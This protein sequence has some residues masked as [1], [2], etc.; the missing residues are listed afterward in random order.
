MN[1]VDTVALALAMMFQDI[2]IQKSE[3][4]LKRAWKAVK[5]EADSLHRLSKFVPR[6][7]GI[8]RIGMKQRQPSLSF[9]PANDSAISDAYASPVE[10]IEGSG[11]I[12]TMSQIGEGPSDGKR[13]DKATLLSD[14]SVGDC[15]VAPSLQWTSSFGLTD[16]SYLLLQSLTRTYAR[17]C[18][19]DLKMGTETFEP[20]CSDEKRR[21][22]SSKYAMQGVFGFRI[23]GMRIYDPD[24]QE[25]D[26]K[27]F[28]L[29]P[30]HYG[31]SLLEREQVVEA[32]RLF[33]GSG[34]K[35]K[36]AAAEGAQSQSLNG[37]ANATSASSV[38][39]RRML[40]DEDKCS[41]VRT[42]AVSSLLLQL[43]SLRRWFEE[44]N[45]A[46]QFR[47][48]SL[49]FIYEGDPTRGGNGDV[50]MLKMI[51]FGHVRR[52]PGGD[53]GYLNGI[54]NLTLILTEIL[55]YDE[56]ARPS[57]NRTLPAPQMEGLPAPQ[58][59]GR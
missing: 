13:G 14:P 35:R 39:H 32:F 27:G 25:S 7:R 37:S 4:E 55:T 2:V 17:P 33:F 46:L 22:E 15:H 11:S 6:C 9:T 45:T 21:R 18:V 52:A 1:V 49:L 3:E 12:A 38:H 16:D 53:T 47:A 42:K 29:F 30:K 54:K 57:T 41:S 56:V 23:I 50:T 5:R 48:S 59:E 43:R 28:R 51:D 10:C 34:V 19:M 20:D 58:M 26:D 36:S 44:H 40:D 31:R 24:H 8:V